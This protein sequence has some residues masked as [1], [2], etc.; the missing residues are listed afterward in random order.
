MTTKED[1]GFKAMGTPPYPTP[2]S[3]APGVKSATL[4]LARIK[5]VNEVDIFIVSNTLDLATDF[6]CVELDRRGSSYL[7][8]NRDLLSTYEVIFDVLGGTLLVNIDNTRF[9]IS[10]E[11]LKSVYYRAPIYLRDIYRPDISPEVQLSRTQWMG[12][13]RNLTVFDDAKWMNHP[14]ATFKAEN[15]LLQLRVARNMG[16]EC[17]DTFVTNCS[18][19]TTS[20]HKKYIVKSIDTALL[21]IDDKEAFVYSNVVDG[22]D[23][24]SFD[25]SIA[26]IIVQTYIQPK[27]DIRVTIINEIVYAVRILK[28]GEGVEGDW[29]R[30]KNDI[31]FVPFSLP[32][33]VAANCVNIVKSLG[34][35]FGGMD[36]IES[37]GMYIFLEVN[38]TGEWGWLVNSSKLR[39]P[40]AIC[41]FLES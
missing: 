13:V 18:H 27:I 4:R 30:I 1:S 16:M 15:K 20:K 9:E 38:P 23:F 19:G 8:L 14:S 12:F 25:N 40:E 11:R 6:V 3:V 21:R 35:C 5:R 31:E 29:R 22:L 41:D 26:P 33:E 34:L 24:A 2:H 37:N 36:L 10:N 7:R 17:P 39:I 28:N 32:D